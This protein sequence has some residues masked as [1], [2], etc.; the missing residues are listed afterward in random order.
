MRY[1][2]IG[3]G[4]IGGVLGGRLFQHG[5][6]VLLVARGENYRTLAREGLRLAS[7]ETVDQ[8]TVPVADGTSA[9]S[10]RADDVIVLAVKGQDTEEVLRGLSAAA[11]PS[12]RIICAQ[13]GVEN[14]RLAAR[15][16][17]DVYA[18]CVLCPSAH[19]APGS[20]EVFA[21]PRGGVFDL[22]RWPQRV[23]GVSEIVA[24]DLEA[25][26]LLAR[27][28]SD[29]GLMKW[30]KLMSNLFNSY[31]ALC[32]SGGAKSEFTRRVRDEAVAVL[33]EEG[34]D[35]RAG[36]ALVRERGS[37]INY[38]PVAGQQRGGGSSWQSL[39][40]G[41][42]DIETDF[43]NGE[44]VLLG[45]MYGIATPANEILQRRANE[46]ARQKLKPGSCTDEELESELN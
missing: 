36:E 39:A 13:N 11:P 28:R 14:E 38:Q 33:T 9:V 41:K 43:L 40:R 10:F 7:P 16:F 44:I 32:G 27:S 4:A 2:V 12:V 34:V 3:A 5:H 29:V 18:M 17:A 21:G 19:L 20:V 35:V 22:G 26:N 30:G 31:E 15:H 24:A 45:R 1:V 8:L 37:L 6:D 25:S 23:D 46:A 42:G